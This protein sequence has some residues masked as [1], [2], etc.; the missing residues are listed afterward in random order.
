MV[1]TMPSSKIIIL[2]LIP[3]TGAQI[4]VPSPFSWSGWISPEIS[5]AE[6]EQT[7]KQSVD[8]NEIRF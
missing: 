7:N 6:I 3:P 8:E 4:P 2:T 5:S 1:D